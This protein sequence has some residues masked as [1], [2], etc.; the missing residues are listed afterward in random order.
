V[1]LI[2]SS[3]GDCP[4]PPPT[5]LQLAEQVGGIQDVQVPDVSSSSDATLSLAGMAAGGLITIKKNLGTAGRALGGE[6]GEEFPLLAN[7]LRPL[8]EDYKKGRRIHNISS[9]GAAVVM[10]V[11]GGARVPLLAGA[12]FTSQTGDTQSPATVA[13]VTG[14]GY[15][16]WNL[17]SGE[18]TNWA[19]DRHLGSVRQLSQRLPTLVHAGAKL[20]GYETP[21]AID[22]DRNYITQAG[23]RAKRALVEPLHHGFAVMGS[24]TPY[25]VTAN[26]QGRTS[27]ERHRLILRS[28]RNSG[29]AAA[30]FFGG[31]AQAIALLKDSHPAAAEWLETKTTNP[32]YL[33]AL[34][35]LIAVAPQIPAISRFVRQRHNDWQ[36]EKA[37]AKALALKSGDR[38]PA[39]TPTASVPPILLTSWL[40]QA[41]R[42][43]GELGEPVPFRTVI[44]RALP[45]PQDVT[46][47]HKE[48]AK[49]TGTLPLT[50]GSH[51]RKG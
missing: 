9:L 29:F 1:S 2:E 26:M 51:F 10:Q 15:C 11:L 19:M 45:H 16:L 5:P 13:A 31:A 40:A 20:P 22:R 12:Y 48:Y 49:R 24:I 33:T 34:G 23:Q 47:R 6:L 39:E 8:R 32:R 30:V 46:C 14:V 27:S 3:G 37:H 50:A 18:A 43:R 28:S 38:P 41:L 35:I 21:I 42:F 25:A 4:S 7:A 17:G 44:P 36:A